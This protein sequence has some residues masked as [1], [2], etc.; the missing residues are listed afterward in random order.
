MAKKEWLDHSTIYS[1]QHHSFYR[2]I[3][4]PVILLLFL[5][6]LFLFFIKKEIVIKTSAQLTAETKILQVPINTKIIENKLNEN[7]RVKKGESLILFDTSNLSSE[8]EQIKQQNASIESQ[9]KA[10]NLFVDS[11]TQGANL[12]EEEDSFGYSNQLKSLFLEQSSNDYLVKQKVEED[13]KAQDSYNK[14]KNQLTQQIQALQNDTNQWNIV[15]SAW[16]NQQGVQDGSSEI[17]AQFQAWRS[18]LENTSEEQKSQINATILS[19]IEE[20]ISQLKKEIEQIQVE[21]SKLS[22]PINY[23]NE[24]NSQNEKIKQTKE[25]ALATTKQKL[26]ELTDDQKKND[27]AIQSL[28]DQISQGNLVAPTDGIIHVNEEIRGQQEIPKGTLLAEIYPL[29]SNE[30]LEFT[31]LIP[32]NEMTHVK[33]GMKVHFKLDKKGVE[34]VIMSGKLKEIAE[35]STNTKQGGLFSVKGELFPTK[36]IPNRYGLTGELSLIVGEKTYW[37]SIKDTILN[38]D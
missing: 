35:K 11:L 29:S 22:P 21:Q 16:I 4:Y 15:R 26:S 28:T 14:T 3:M 5:V 13:Q 36:K 6:G 31:A 38:R 7:Q 24:I 32:A 12:F 17:Q 8:K 27:L 10:C 18:Q 19:T 1:H 37:Q 34:P 9:K 33:T 30:N 20:H 2:W 25:Q 23:D